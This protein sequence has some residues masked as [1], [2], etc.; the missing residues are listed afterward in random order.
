[1]AKKEEMMTKTKK[2]T[3]TYQKDNVSLS[4]TLSVDT[5]SELRKFLRLLEEAVKDLTEDINSMNN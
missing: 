1:M 5:S 3:Y 4:F 2:K